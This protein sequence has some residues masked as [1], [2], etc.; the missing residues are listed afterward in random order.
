[1]IRLSIF[2]GLVK[3]VLLSIF[4]VIAIATLMFLWEMG[5]DRC[6]SS[7]FDMFGFRTV[8][9]DEPYAF[10]ESGVFSWGI[11]SIGPNL[12]LVN[13]SVENVNVGQCAVPLKNIK[14]PYRLTPDKHM[15]AI[16]SGCT[17]MG[18]HYNGTYQ[19]RINFTLKSDDGSIT[20]SRGYVVGRAMT[21]GC[22]WY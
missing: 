21:G 22:S 15:P 9:P 2:R 18:Y 10:D 20:E 1:M 5:I 12:T 4:I 16:S 14:L 3:L 7:N 6:P 8:Y 19:L 17:P 13:V 11:R